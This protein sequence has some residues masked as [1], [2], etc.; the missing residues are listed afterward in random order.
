MM[1]VENRLLFPVLHPEIAWDR[2]VVLVNFPIP[3]FPVKELALSDANPLNNLLGRCFSPL[4]PVVGV[5]DDGVSR[6]VG[7]PAPC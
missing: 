2:A 7:N 3:F 4:G 6:V 1:E 5:V